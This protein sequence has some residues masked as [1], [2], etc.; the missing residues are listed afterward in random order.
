MMTNSLR[1]D[2]C[3]EKYTATPGRDFVVGREGDLEIDD[4]PYLHRRFL[5]LTEERGLWWIANV[6]TLL[7]ATI[8]DGSGGVQ[9]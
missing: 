2:F 4:N 9:A 8:T 5:L 6:G 1:I 3:G 7:S